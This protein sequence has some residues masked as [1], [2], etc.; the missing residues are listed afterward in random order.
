MTVYDLVGVGLGPFNL[1]L[2][3]LA[4]GVAG[5]RSL[6]LERR[7]AFSWHPGLML[8]GATMQTSFLKDLVT[9][10]CPT[11]PWSFVNF[12]VRHGRFDDFLAGRFETASRKEF[13]AY[14]AWAA[15]GL[16]AARF[17][18]DVR[19]VSHD[20][21]LFD[22][23][24]SDNSRFRTRSVS[25]AV[26]RA[27][28]TPD[29]APLG[30]RCFHASEWLHRNPETSG[31]RVVVIGGGQTGAEIVLTLL[32][33]HRVP[34]KII[35]ISRR[36]NFWTLQDGAFIDQFFTPAYMKFWRALPAPQRRHML[37]EQKY[38]SDGITAATANA[39]YRELYGQRYLDRS[40]RL[41]LHPGRDVF[42]IEAAAA[43][44]DIRARHLDKTTETFS[45]DLVVLATGYGADLPSC[46]APL[47]DR[48]DRH[49]SGSLALDGRYRVKWDGPL[50]T[51][52]YALNHGLLSHGIIDPQMSLAAWRSAVVLNDVTGR[53]VFQ[54]DQKPEEL[55]GWSSC[56][57]RRPGI[58]ACNQP[59]A[60]SAA[61]VVGGCGID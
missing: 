37:E 22:I 35:W 27:P 31:R 9:P 55:V 18:S 61:R 36:S 20:G 3:A 44:Y 8:P 1:S 49:D 7:A 10:V 25:I 51:P 21:K 59:R 41:S 17:T 15:H 39:I 60:C 29:F 32:R 43:R 48:L 57:D 12:L 6:F 50:D 26:G 19:D 42:A 23:R 53:E 14:L 52:L 58:P 56:T 40:D 54:I 38:T 45:A 33:A 47:A 11:S 4:D 13:N 28:N 30:E 2:A 16:D 5:L 24:L 34:S 46:L